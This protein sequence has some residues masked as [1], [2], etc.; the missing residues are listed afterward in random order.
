MPVNFSTPEPMQK[1]SHKTFL[2]VALFVQIFISLHFPLFLLM[3][4]MFLKLYFINF[5]IHFL[6]LY[7]CSGTAILR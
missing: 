3:H 4:N 5:A 7:F 1:Y 6:L 2:V